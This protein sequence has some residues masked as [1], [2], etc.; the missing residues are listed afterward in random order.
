MIL[1]IGDAPLSSVADFRVDG[2]VPEFW[3]C[4]EDEENL[5]HESPDEAVLMY[6][7]QSPIYQQT[8]VYGFARMNAEVRFDPL[9]QVLR[10]LDENYGGHE[11]MDE[12]PEMREATD[13]YIAHIAR[14][15]RVERYEVIVGYECNTAQWIARCAPQ[16]IG[17]ITMLGPRGCA[18][19]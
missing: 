13:R 10:H 3:S 14:L 12:T 1:Q 18:G 4:R 17:E 7:D 19:H 5:V 8:V 16:W 9:P 6:L 2:R 11:A 15:Y